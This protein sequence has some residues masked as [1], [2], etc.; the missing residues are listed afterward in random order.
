MYAPDMPV[1]GIEEYFDK[2]F[3]N[4]HYEEFKKAYELLSDEE[5]RAV[6]T[7]VINYK[8][9]GKIKYLLECYS[10]R[11]EIYSLLGCNK[12]RVAVDAGAYNGDTAKEMIEYFPFVNRIYALEP[13]KKNFKKL[14]RYSEA[15]SSNRIIP[16][17]AAAWC[18]DT[19]GMF[20]GSGNRNSTAVA[21]A[22]YEHNTGDVRMV[23]IDSVTDD[24]VDYIK[25]DVEG[26]EREAL[27]GSHNTILNYSPNLLISLYHRSRDIFDLI[28]LFNDRY[29]N[30]KLYLRRLRCLPAWEIDLICVNDP[31]G[32]N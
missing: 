24:K 15:E 3:Y 23:Q 25:Y 21:T 32:N 7:S 26:A 17:N 30:Y 19:S 11:S 31:K 6:F 29:P 4:S 12:I 10:E 27:L 16:I 28:N 22:S 13:D 8:I 9:T 5:S 20:Y 1:A 14:G 18:D 2:E